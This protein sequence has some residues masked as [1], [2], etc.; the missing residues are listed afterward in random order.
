M[1]EGGRLIVILIYWSLTRGLKGVG[2][3]MGEQ[4]ITR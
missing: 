3:D 1:V 4:F 2:N